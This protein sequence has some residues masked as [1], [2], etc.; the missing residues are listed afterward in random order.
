LVARFGRDAIFKDVNSIPLGTDF[1]QVLGEAMA[2][3]QVALVIIGEQWLNTTDGTG[4][5][6]LDS[7][8]DFVRIEIET[9]LARE[10]PIIP[11]GSV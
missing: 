5:R 7:E 10:I 6:R 2:K 1:R 3:C 11:L 9:A 8:Q 4:N